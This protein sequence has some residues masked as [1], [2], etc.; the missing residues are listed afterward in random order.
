[1][2]GVRDIAGIGVEGLAGVRVLVVGL[3]RTGVATSRFLARAGAAVTAT[4][5]RA[6]E[7]I[8]GARELASL[9][10]EL[11]C[12]GHDGVDPNEPELIVVSP[13]VPFDIP[14][15][16]QALRAGVEIISD[17]ELAG[18]FIKVPLV[19][20]TG[21]NGKSTTTLLIDHLLRSAGKNVFVG[22]NIGT[23]ALVFV[24]KGQVEDYCVLEVSSFH[25]EAIS[26]FR[27]HIGVLL[28]ITQDHL[29]RYK[30]FD[31]YVHTKFRLFSNQKQGDLAVLNV[32]DPVIAKAA[33]RMP[34]QWKVLPFTSNGV[35][36]HG[37]YLRENEIVR[38]EDE[39]EE[40]YALESF[41]L[42][43]RHNAE[44]LMAAIA[45]ARTLDVPS[46]VIRE[47]LSGFT[48]LPHRMELIRELDGVR[49]ID[50]SK[51]TNPGAVLAAL[52]GMDG[53]VILIA[54]GKDKGLDYG[55]L[56]LPVAKKC[57]LVV[58]MGEAAP[59]I[60]KAITGATE[61]LIMGTMEEAVLLASSRSAPNDTV[62]LSPA[63]A[64]FDMYN[65]FAERGEAFQKAVGAL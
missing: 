65:G 13:G 61:T 64:S 29:Y 55:V 33:S 20:I 12:G 17:I 6:S 58:L 57:K 21:T 49:F 23:P 1:M 53:Q 41:A 63:C 44:N 51:A 24:E 56:K 31:G 46:E 45:V 9:N 32:G 10:V 35:L 42:P 27:P 15:I 38:I 22:G 26:H 52:E 34:L 40:V 19:A 25:L 62:L 60:K 47:A 2:T 7:E 30:D 39:T 3:G 18:R 4:D 48:G 36:T 11:K 50:D 8:D 16:S 59:S 37:M 14:L 5:T 54:G 43:G 28:N